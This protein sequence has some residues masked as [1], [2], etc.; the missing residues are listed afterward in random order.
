MILNIL[1]TG[2]AILNYHRICP[3][4]NSSSY[5]DE[6][7]VSETKFKEQLIYLKKNYKLVCL[8]EL[9]NFKKDNKPKVSITFDDGYKD[10][11]TYAMPILTELNVPATIYVVTK[12]FEEGF[13]AWWYELQ[14]YIW[15]NS[16]NIK[17]TY[18]KKNYDFTITKDSK[19]LECFITL[20]KIIKK[21]NKSEQEKFLHLPTLKEQLLILQYHLEKL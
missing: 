9:L 6:L 21:L 16:K 5:S 20:K 1:S 14:D 4:N 7:A 2:D 19:K 12:S 11:L 13:N 18:N 10:N 8:D 17:F 3:D 15:Q